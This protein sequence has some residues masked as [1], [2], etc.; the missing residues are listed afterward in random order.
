[1]LYDAVA[2]LPSEAGAALLAQDAAAKDFVT[3][4]F[5]HCKF[6]AYSDGAMPLLE[7][8]GIASDL[9]GGC[10][11]LDGGKG[12]GAFVKACRGLRFWKRAEMFG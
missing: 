1:V 10:I 4:A 8:A 7:A 5:A 9:D 6:I 2:V 11:K 12:A 3:D